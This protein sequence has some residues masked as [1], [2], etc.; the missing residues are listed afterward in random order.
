MNYSVLLGI[1]RAGRDT[2]RRLT[3]Q[4]CE[5][6]PLS[7]GIAAEKLADRVLEDPCTMYT[8]AMRVQPVIP[9]IPIA[10]AMPRVRDL[11]MAA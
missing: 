6:D 2:G 3:L 1:D 10:T 7:A 5:R 4:V 11:A 8:H 9:P